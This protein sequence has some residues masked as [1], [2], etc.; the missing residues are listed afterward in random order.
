MNISLLL[1]GAVLFLSLASCKGNGKKGDNQSAN[2]GKNFNVKFIK[3]WTEDVTDKE[4]GDSVNVKGGAEDHDLKVK[5]EGC[6]N[7]K[8]TVS[9]DGEASTADS[10]LGVATIRDL[11]IPATK[12]GAELVIKLTADGM[13]EYRKSLTIKRNDSSANVTVTAKLATTEAAIAVMN[14]QK[15]ETEMESVNVEVVSAVDIATVKIAGEDAT[16]DGTKKASKLIRVGEVGASVE[17]NVELTF[18]YH[19][20]FTTKFK[21]VRVAAG[22]RP[23]EPMK[24]TLYSG[25]NYGTPHELTLKDGAYTCDALDDIEYSVVK[26][27]MEM[28]GTPTKAEITKCIDERVD[29]YAEGKMTKKDQLGL[30]S[31]RLTKEI[32]AE[33]AETTFNSIEGSKYTEYLIVGAAKVGYDFSFEATGRKPTTAKVAIENKNTK[34]LGKDTGAVYSSM[35]MAQ[36]ALGFNSNSFMWFGFIQ[37][38]INKGGD[39]DAFIKSQSNPEYMGDTVGMYFEFPAAAVDNSLVYFYYHLF[40]DRKTEAVHNFVRI[41]GSPYQTT[42]QTLTAE[43]NPEEKHIDAFVGAKKLLP[44]YVMPLSLANKWKRVVKKGF[45]LRVRNELTIAGN[46]LSPVGIDF[47]RVFSYRNLTKIYEDNNKDHSTSPKPVK[48]GKVQKYKEPLNGVEKPCQTFLKGGKADLFM[49]IPTFLKDDEKNMAN[50]ISSIKYTIK[51]GDADTSL[52][53]DTDYKDISIDPSKFQVILLGTKDDSFGFDGKLIPEKRYQFEDNKVYQIDV[54]TTLKD[55][56]KEYFTY[57]IY[58]TDAEQMMDNY[59]TDSDYSGELFG[60]PFDMEAIEAGQLSSVREEKALN[61][62]FAR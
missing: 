16:L 2:G 53:E 59:E 51:K 61:A 31:G 9:V 28:N 37:E 43:F 12:A 13:N 45:N 42:H 4:N 41:V 55:S 24:V 8:L 19:K 32:S 1:A 49:M 39:S 44:I 38:K 15:Y 11:D 36:D 22:Q 7:Y 52:T 14:D 33:G 26:L 10:S 21:L 62:V 50:H 46:R 23:I 25:E 40:D 58:Y 6:D 54:E 34:I 48:I 29:T 30:F 56:S 17:V 57:Q 47:T 35:Y 5:V 18:K 20:A 3:L 27:V 60:V